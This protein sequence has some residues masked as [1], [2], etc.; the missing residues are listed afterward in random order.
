MDLPRVYHTTVV[1]AVQE[2]RLILLIWARQIGKTT[3]LKY[4]QSH[5]HTQMP[6]C[7]VTC[8]QR[9]QQPFHSLA[10]CKQW[11]LYEHQFDTSKSWLLLLDEIQQWSDPDLLLKSLYDDPTV[12]CRVVATGSRFWWQHHVWAS[13]VGRGKLFYLHTLSFK[14]FLWRKGKHIH[15]MTDIQFEWIQDLLKEYLTWWWYPAVVL[16]PTKQKK[17]EALESIIETRLQKDFAF[18]LSKELLSPFRQL[19]R[20]I[21]LNTGNIYK[22]DQLAS[23]VWVSK[24]HID[25]MIQFMKDSYLI[26]SIAPFYEDK[27]KEYSQHH[28]LFFHDLGLLQYICGYSIDPFTDGKLIETLVIDN[29]VRLCGLQAVH[30]YKKKSGAEID[31]IIR[32]AHNNLIPIEIKAG[33]KHQYSSAI[34]NFVKQYGDRI[35]HTYMTSQSLSQ[36]EHPTYSHHTVLP[37]RATE[38]IDS[39]SKQNNIL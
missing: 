30:F 19:W 10:E 2:H 11:L 17:Q 27:S 35:S 23:K 29:L 5:Y 13:L 20:H 15:S 34:N 38:D 22:S 25:Q 4:L 8:D 12:Q 7:F 31:A 39:M 33:N 1:Q 3:L 36:K 14:E 21:A 6:V 16:A 18:W 32:L 24:Y 9:Y 26:Y 37:Y 28:E